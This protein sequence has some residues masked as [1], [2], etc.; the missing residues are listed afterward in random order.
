MSGL[1]DVV[2]QGMI[3]NGFWLTVFLVSVITFRKP[4]RS[5]IASLGK[6]NIAGASFELREPSATLASYVM[7]G[8]VLVD[9]LSERESAEKL[10]PVMSQASAQQLVRFIGKYMEEVPLEDQNI[11][12]LKNV[13]LLIGRKKQYQLAIGLYDQLLKRYP[14]DGDLL[15]LKARMLRDSGNPEGAEPLYEELVTKTPVHS[16]MW[17]GRAR[18]RSLLRKFPESLQDLERAIELGYWKAVPNMMDDHQLDPLRKAD[19]V[20]FDRLRAE[21][22]RLSGRASS[23]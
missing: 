18:T 5:A 7:L 4:L 16:G 23:L 6:F 12:M 3:S 19:P 9:I 20:G 10:Y 13:A 2:V 14:G 15:Y 21:L 11:E 22:A 8:N 17:F 1:S